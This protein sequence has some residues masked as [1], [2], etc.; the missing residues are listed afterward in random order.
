MIHDEEEEGL[1]LRRIDY[2]IEAAASAILEAG[3]PEKLAARLR[4]GS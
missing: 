2:N 1:W 4:T 3:L